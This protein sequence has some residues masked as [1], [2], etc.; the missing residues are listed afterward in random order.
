MTCAGQG[1]S[2]FEIAGNELLQSCS[3]SDANRVLVVGCSAALCKL[4]SDM[5]GHLRAVYSGPK[6]YS[7]KSARDRG[8]PTL[9]LNTRKTY[10]C[11]FEF[12]R[13]SSKQIH[14][15]LCCHGQPEMSTNS[16]PESEKSGKQ[17]TASLPTSSP[18][19]D[20]GFKAWI[21]VAGAWCC[22]FCS[23]GYVNCIGLFEAQY[24]RDQLRNYSH[25]TV[26][27]ITSLEVSS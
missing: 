18:P 27:W 26:A 11:V 16:E 12:P 21:V 22:L 23:F 1:T 10:H 2:D 3:Y 15:V 4:R 24:Q 9:R 17:P 8:S 6:W 13:L 25:S 19:P 5:C 7:Q 20:G 14:A